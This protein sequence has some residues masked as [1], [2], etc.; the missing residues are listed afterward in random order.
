M[1]ALAGVNLSVLKGIDD[2]SLKGVTLTFSFST[3]IFNLDALSQYNSYVRSFRVT[4]LDTLAEL[5]YVFDEVRAVPI[6]V[7]ILTDDSQKGWT[8]LIQVTPDGVTGNGLIEVE[9]V[10][11]ENAE[12][13]RN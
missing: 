10:K 9:L 1:I 5:T 3:A 13:G 12:I 11:R 8:S 2:Q 4:N 6:P 7:P